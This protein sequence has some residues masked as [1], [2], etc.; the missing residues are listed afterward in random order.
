EDACLFEDECEEEASHYD[1]DE[2]HVDLEASH[3]V[4]ML[5]EKI[6][7]GVEEE[8]CD[9]LQQNLDEEHFHNGPNSSGHKEEPILEF[10]QIQN[11]ARP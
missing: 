5:V 7:H 9:A 1:K 4:D 10:V 3:H 11:Q 6:V 2:E 8:V